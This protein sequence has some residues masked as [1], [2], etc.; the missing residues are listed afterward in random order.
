MISEAEHVAY[1]VDHLV[2][3]VLGYEPDKTG[4]VS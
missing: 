1:L 4:T 2:A 3:K